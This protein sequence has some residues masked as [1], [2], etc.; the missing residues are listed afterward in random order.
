MTSEVPSVPS[1]PLSL[2][3][4]GLIIPHSTYEHRLMLHPHSHTHRVE[5]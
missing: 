4:G 5:H 3:D 1:A 2:V